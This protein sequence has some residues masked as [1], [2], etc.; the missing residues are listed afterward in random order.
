MGYRRMRKRDLWEIYRRRQAGQSVSRIAANEGRDRKT[1]R[2]YLEG[3]A[4]LGLERSEA[5]V[6]QQRFFQMVE[7]LLPG[8]TERP[9]PGVEQLTPYVQ[10]LRALINDKREPLKPKTAFLVVRARHDLAVSYETFKRFA[11][12]QGLSRAERRRMIRIELPPGLETQLDYGKVGT[13][14]DPRRGAKGVVWAFCGVLAFSRLPYV[15]FVWSQDQSGFVSSV[16]G[17]LEYYGGST[18]FLSPDNLKAAVAKPDLWDP[19]INR[20]LS[21]AAEHYGVFI[22]PCRVGRSTDKA[23]IERFIPVARELFRMLKALHPSADL[24]ELNRL[25]L[26]W[27]R[28][29]YGRREHGTTGVAPIEAFGEERV[30]LRPLPPERFVVPIWKPVKVHPG[31]Q[32]LVFA[33]RRFSL[34]AAWKGKQVWARYGAPMLSLYHDERLIRQ[35]VVEERKKIYWVPEDFPKEVRHM[36]NGGY[37]AW[38]VESARAYGTDAVELIGSVLQPHAYLNARRARGMLDIMAAH[39][40]RPYFAEVCRRAR[41]RS[42][43]LPV[44]LKRMLEA[45]ERQPVFQQPLPISE[46]GAQMV[47][48]IDYYT[49]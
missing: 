42:V 31:D 3:L 10:E 33:G 23:K 19:Q 9:A 11:R 46:L 20:A 5:A 27:C 7:G 43:V 45:A 40:G 37:P 39:H 32:F 21:E 18:E 26:Q 29:D 25:A 12:N 8:Q 48:K 47:R 4:T 38:I 14:P 36:M 44:T 6:E 22:D 17:M 15:E 34:P 1:V 35:Y 49:N 16:V 41:R 30:R 2:V 13:L 24:A 28:E